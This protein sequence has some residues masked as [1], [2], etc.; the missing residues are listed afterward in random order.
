MPQDRKRQ[1][2]NILITGTPGT[3]KTT[4]SSALADAAQLR[5]VSIGDLVKE[6]SLHDG[7]D[8]EL[9]CYVI[10]EDLVSS[11]PL[12]LLIPSPLYS[13]Y[14]FHW[15]FPRIEILRCAMSWRIW[16]KKVESLWTITVVIFFLS[17]G[18]IALSFSKLRTPFC[19]TDWRR[20]KEIK[21]CLCRLFIHYDSLAQGILLWNCQKICIDS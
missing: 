21:A 9:Q 2:P 18:L 6:K 11:F 3:G 20:G 12:E 16:W 7:W 10:N 13:N 19:T 5:H 4:T 17:G 14:E 1:R 8:D 15:S